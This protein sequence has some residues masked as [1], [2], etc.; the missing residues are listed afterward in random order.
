MR[1]LLAVLLAGAT[2]LSSV[3]ASAQVVARVSA[4]AATAAPAASAAARAGAA[5]V[6]SLVPSGAF[7]GELALQTRTLSAATAP[8]P[9]AF[10]KTL[11]PA[12]A[13]AAGPE[14]FAA[15]AALVTALAAPKTALPA[16]IKAVSAADTKKS[17]KAA[18]ALNA[19]RR[20]IAQAPAAERRDLAAAA[21]ELNARFDGASAAPGEAVDLAALPTD[22][23]RA[24][25]KSALRA[26]K[27]DRRKLRLLQE[28]LAA[29]KEHA[30]LVV[31]QGMDAAGK[32]GV[33]KRSLLLNPAW[34][35]VAAFKKPTDEEAKQDFLERIKKQVPEKGMLGIFNRSQYE[36]ILVPKVL[37]T[38]SKE[39]IETRYRRINE[40]ERDL[41]A[42]GV[43]I[44]KIFLH[45][46]KSMQKTRLQRRID[47]PDKRWKLS[48][49]DLKSRARWGDF[50]AAYADVLAR[51]STPWAPW[52]IVPADD[53]PRRNAEVAH[54]VRK[55]LTRLAPRFPD[56]PDV[57]GVTIPD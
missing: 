16:L 18:K 46:S 7:L 36:D 26:M 45:E 13:P 38:F 37:G 54:L 6:L 24:G 49:D 1:R 14:A 33:I 35:K 11:A 17:G 53:K 41:V 55:A 40:F 42:S 47:R 22:E 15:R 56:P 57:K 43:L 51:T 32:D 21:A 23:G 30:V 3:S 19:L 10:L 39:E 4:T 2:L 29:S 28:A 52:R 25:P 9:Q 48:L 44:V 5:P 12:P 31:I 34:T 8:L 27:K 20:T 50:Q